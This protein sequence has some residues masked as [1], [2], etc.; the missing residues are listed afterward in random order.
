MENSKERR[1]RKEELVKSKNGI[2]GCASDKKS[3][4]AGQNKRNS[5]HETLT[6]VLSKDD[7][8]LSVATV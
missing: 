6:S 5:F 1:K 3:E 7:I 4:T 8:L 2:I